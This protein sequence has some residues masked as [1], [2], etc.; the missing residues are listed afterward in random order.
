MERTETHIHDDSFKFRNIKSSEFNGGL[1]PDWEKKRVYW[2]NTNP[3]FDKSVKYWDFIK[4]LKSTTSVVPWLIK[5]HNKFFV[6]AQS[7][8]YRLDE[9]C[10]I[11][12]SDKKGKYD[13]L[14]PIA[15]YRSYIDIE[16]ACDRFAQEY[17][18]MLINQKSEEV[19]FLFDNNE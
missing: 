18:A 8:M 13:N 10:S 17:M 2:R 12:E 19:S 16:S 6:V 5:L 15:I 4:I 14:N 3:D 1:V 7:T 11:Y 9:V